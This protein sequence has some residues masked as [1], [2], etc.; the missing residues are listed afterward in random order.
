MAQQHGL[1]PA[2][3]CSLPSSPIAHVSCCCCCRLLPHC[4]ATTMHTHTHRRRKPLLP[5]SY[6]HITPSPNSQAFSPDPSFFPSF[7]YAL[8]SCSLSLLFSL[9]QAHTLFETCGGQSPMVASAACMFPHPHHH[10]L[11]LTFIT[12]SPIT[13]CIQ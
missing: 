12:F 9:L 10:P 5:T 8:F 4:N 2:P 3:G 6:Y 11:S 13:F 7:S 1:L